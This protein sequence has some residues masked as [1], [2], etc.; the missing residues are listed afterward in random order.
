MGL[1]A[2]AHLHQT[3]AVEVPVPDGRVLR[4]AN[5]LG[6]HAPVCAFPQ[7]HLD[8]SPLSHQARTQQGQVPAP[9]QRNTSPSRRQRR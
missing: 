4:S 1:S 2:F 6:R 8:Q 3:G 7:G 5:L 9:H